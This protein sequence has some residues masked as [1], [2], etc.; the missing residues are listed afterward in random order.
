MTEINENQK[1]KLKELEGAIKDAYKEGRYDLVRDLAS[2]IRAINPEDRLGAKLLSKVEE[3]KAEA[4]KKEKSAKTK[5]YESMLTKL[6]KEGNF[7]NFRK[8]ASEF[9]LFDPE[10]KA[11]DGLLAKVIKAEGEAKRKANEGKIKELE[12]MLKVA[13]KEARFEEVKNLAAK[14]NEL[15]PGNKCAAGYLADM[16]KAKMEAKRKE[17]AEKI[18]NL[19]DVIKTSFKEGR[20]EEVKIASK[21]L[22]E[23]D[24]ENSFYKKYLAQVAEIETKVQKEKAVKPAVVAPKAVAVPDIKKEEKVGVFAKMFAKKEE[25]VKPAV[26]TPKAVAAPAIKA[27]PAPVVAQKAPEAP[28]PA[29]T[30]PTEEKGNIFTRMFG[31]KEE[32]VKPKESIIDTIVAKTEEVKAKAEEKPRVEKEKGLA[33]AS[34]SK[35]LMQFSIAFIVISAAFF[36]VQNIDQSNTVLGMF[37][38]KDNY[39][40]RLHAASLQLE[41]KKAEESKINGEI[42]VYKEGY[43]N[44][45]ET[46]VGDI[47]AKRVA[48]PDI[49]AKINEIADYIYERNSISQYIKFNNFSLDTA[50]GQ[51]RVSGTLSDPL[52]KNLTKLAELEEAFRYYPKDKNNL[53]DTT[54]PYFYNLQEFNSL[55]KS[56]DTR[57]GKYTSNFQLSFSLAESETE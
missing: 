36:Y 14:L 34:F 8:L 11:M 30:V 23:I 54:K 1:A 42:E 56:Y 17:N 25:Q 9:R 10:S 27:A 26:V 38:V 35:A 12:K 37:G 2:Q 13:F 24:P 44:K 33:F 53:E 51:V 57:T 43:N 15:E 21:K 46:I 20:F 47:V 41:E 3:A 22:A 29:V 40:G 50:T 48:W 7:E 31:K 45:Y 52:G 28:K 39:A 4:L 55:S 6:Y 49:M 5:Q 19:Q 16:E 32:L 18:N